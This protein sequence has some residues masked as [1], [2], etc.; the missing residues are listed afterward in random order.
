VK[1][2]ESLVDGFT[3]APLPP[4]FVSSAAGTFPPPIGE[5]TKGAVQ[6]DS[7]A[8]AQHCALGDRVQ[9]VVVAESERRTQRG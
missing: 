8:N 4:A 2:S 1:L 9:E 6:T 7:Q 5:G 3:A